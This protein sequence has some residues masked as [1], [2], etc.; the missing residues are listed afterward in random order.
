M[1]ALTMMLV[2]S[3]VPVEDDSLDQF[4]GVYDVRT[5]QCRC[6]EHLDRLEAVEQLYGWENGRWAAWRDEVGEV[7]A[8]WKLLEEC[9][10]QPSC[11][12]RAA[13]VRLLKERI[14]AK[15]FDEGWRPREMPGSWV[16]R[17]D[18]KP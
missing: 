17:D 3:L 18:S 7:L 9:H 14:G 12:L 15:N 13:A 5:Q 1:D 11:P 8:Y 2:L 10:T 4:P 6:Q 16:F